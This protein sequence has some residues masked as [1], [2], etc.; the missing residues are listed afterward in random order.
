MTRDELITKIGELLFD[1]IWARYQM[2]KRTY[3]DVAAMAE[4]RERVAE[5]RAL[6]AAVDDGMVL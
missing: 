1:G 6:S 2:T 4:L 5:L 3:G